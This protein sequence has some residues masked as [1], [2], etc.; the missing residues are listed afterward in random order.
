M[1]SKSHLVIITV[2][3]VPSDDLAPSY[4]DICKTDYYKIR[5]PY[6]RTS[7]PESGICDMEK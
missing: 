5:I 4:K 2:M 3:T 1:C 7:E 6:I